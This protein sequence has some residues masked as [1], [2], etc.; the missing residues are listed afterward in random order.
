MRQLQRCSVMALQRPKVWALAVVSLWIFGFMIR[1]NPSHWMQ[2]RRLRWTPPRI[3]LR[4]R[5]I[6]WRGKWV[7]RWRDNVWI[8]VGRVAMLMDW[9]SNIF[10]FLDSPLS[11]G[12]PGE[13][14][15]YWELKRKYGTDMPW[16]ALIEPSI[17]ICENGFKLSKHMSDF[18]EK[19]IKIKDS[20]LW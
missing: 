2:K 10:I 6:I 14:K 15:G 8:Q 16:K 5:K 19:R 1:K 18:I 7:S 11:I 9:F 4:H 3:C 12:V 20:P 13:V 17:E